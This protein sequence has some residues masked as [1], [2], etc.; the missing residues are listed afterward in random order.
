MLRFILRRRVVDV[1]A[2]IERS[3]LFTIDTAAPDVER[4]LRGG[5]YSE[6]GHDFTELV[7]VEILEEEQPK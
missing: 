4:E 5:G 7:G 1:S 6:H 2:S 3:S